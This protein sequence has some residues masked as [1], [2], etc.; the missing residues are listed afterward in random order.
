M[1]SKRLHLI[2]AALACFIFFSCKRTTEEFKSEPL[3][4]YLP[5]QVGKYIT[6]RVDSTVF[7]NFGTVVAV[8]SFQ[9]KH[10]VDAKITDAQGRESYRILRFTRDTAGTQP[11]APAGAYS[12]TPTDNTIEVIENNLR[13]VKLVKPIKQD[14]TWKGNRYL[15]DDAYDPLF[16]FS[17]VDAGMEDW[18]YTYSSMGDAIAIK[19]QTYNDV[20]TVDAVDAVDNANEKT[21]TVLN[22]SSVAS[23][24]QVQDKYAKGLGLIY[25]KFVMWEYQPPNG[26]N[27]TGAKVGFG[28]VRSIIDHN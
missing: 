20:L 4:N 21:F 18:D 3:S 15:P 16:S 12:I 9:E 23:V 24:N 19:G 17:I 28:I 2:T 11:W 6:Y 22:P 14:N 25:Q 5:L 7:T 27:Q 1:R 10:I 26:S 8:R 13:F